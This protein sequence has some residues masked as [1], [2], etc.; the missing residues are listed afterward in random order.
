MRGP[1]VCESKR[2]GLLQTG[3]EDVKDRAEA[4]ASAAASWN[5][6]KASLEVVFMC[7]YKSP[8]ASPKPW[9]PRLRCSALADALICTVLSGD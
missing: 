7:F 5:E 2:Q 4:S 1:K 9:E 8:T 3:H 6:E